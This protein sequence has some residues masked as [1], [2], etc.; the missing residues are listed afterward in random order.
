MWRVRN[1]KLSEGI[2]RGAVRSNH[3]GVKRPFELDDE[4]MA[5]TC[6]DT[7]FSSHSDDIVFLYRRARWHHM[8]AA[9]EADDSRR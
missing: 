8:A 2:G 6:E 3:W 7:A 1:P 4:R 5:D 9:H